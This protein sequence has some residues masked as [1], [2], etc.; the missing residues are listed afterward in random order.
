MSRQRPRP[1][2]HERD[3]RSTSP[4]RPAAGMTRLNRRISVPDPLYPEPMSGNH[5]WDADR[6]SRAQ[7]RDGNQPVARSMEDLV[8]SG[9]V[10]QGQRHLLAALAARR[11]SVAVISGAAAAGKTTLLNAYLAL[12]PPGVRRIDL[13]GQ[14]E[15]FAWQ[16]DHWI[17]P[18]CTIV[19]AG[20]ISAHLPGYLWGPQVAR[21]AALHRRGFALAA[22]A[23]ADDPAEWL[24]LLTGYP[25]AV[26]PHDAAAF[27]AVLRLGPRPEPSSGMWPFVLADGWSIERSDHDGLIPERL[28]AHGDVHEAA[29]RALL[30]DRER[31]AT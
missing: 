23:H 21:F 22:T 9:V 29:V 3:V 31:P 5:R 24:R 4:D 16:S 30:A 1:G 13:R 25:L 12:M 10:S 17:V 15:T 14:Y 11:I 7:W 27:R 6:S 2:A 8:A 19:V 18:D 26:P 20:E 28:I